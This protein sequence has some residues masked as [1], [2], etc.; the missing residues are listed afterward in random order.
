MPYPKAFHRLVIFGTLYND[1]WATSLSI[2]PNGLGELGMPQVDPTT[3]SAVATIVNTGW[4]QKSVGTGGANVIGSARLTGIKLNRIGPDGKYVDQQAMTHMYPTPIIGNGGSAIIAPQLTTVVTLRTAVERG[5]GSKGRMYLPPVANMASLSSDG[6]L[7]T[8]QAVLVAAAAATLV[9]GLNAYYGSGKVG[10]ASNV[11]SGAF[12]H[13]T[14]L[15]VG[16]V[17]D[18]MRSRRNKQLEDPQRIAIA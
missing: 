18:T 5:R 2:V 13:V 6:R 9:N 11:G 1:T 7:E 15:T 4:W 17:V 12:N 14:A 3:L 10:V 8:A 16:R